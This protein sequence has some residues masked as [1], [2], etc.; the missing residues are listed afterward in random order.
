MRIAL[1]K[2]GV[3]A[4]VVEAALGMH[5]DYVEI[6]SDIANVG[7]SWDGEGFTSVPPIETSPSQD[8]AVQQKITQVTCFQAKVALDYYGLL[9]SVEALM[10][11]AS[12]PIKIKLAWNNGADFKRYSDMVLSMAGLLGLSDGQLDDLFAYAATVE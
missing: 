3:V 12:T 1:I 7:D 11:D 9:A 2:D 8:L 5:T 4:N 10:I 6:A